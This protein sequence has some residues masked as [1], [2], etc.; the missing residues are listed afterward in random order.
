MS[1]I[2]T[3]EDQPRGFWN[4]GRV[5]ELVIGRD[6][7]ARGAVVRVASK[8]R[9][10]TLLQR[11]VQRLYPLESTTPSTT[12]LPQPD[13][14]DPVNTLPLRRSTRAAA[15]EARDRLMAQSLMDSD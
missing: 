15:F 1:L 14:P 4:L 12:A 2:G 3:T 5:E 13:P 11:P 6:G 9:R 7:E 8:G 10:S